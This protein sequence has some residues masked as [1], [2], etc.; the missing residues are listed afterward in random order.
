MAIYIPKDEDE[1]ERLAEPEF[2]SLRKYREHVDYRMGRALA[3]LT[4]ERRLK[5]WNEFKK[6][7]VVW[8]RVSRISVYEFDAIERFKSE[9]EKENGK[10]DPHDAPGFEWFID[11]APVLFSARECMNVDDSD[12]HEGVRFSKIWRDPL[13][14]TIWLA[15]KRRHLTDQYFR[16]HCITQAHWIRKK[17]PREPG[18]LHVHAGGYCSLPLSF[19]RQ[20]WPYVVGILVREKRWPYLIPAGLRYGPIGHVRVAEKITA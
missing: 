12:H 18:D 8:G 3:C 9:L 4:L 6:W 15:L 19:Q 1:L 2:S 10:P 14:R 11:P 20:L 13:V 16:L 7:Q 5:T 17:P